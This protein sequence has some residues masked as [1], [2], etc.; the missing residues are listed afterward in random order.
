[1]EKT[2]F[3]IAILVGKYLG[4]TLTE[5]EE[6]TL[7]DWLSSSEK[8]RAWFER[9]TTKSY[10][11]KKGTD[12]RSVNIEDG[13]KALEN[14]R[15]VRQ[16]RRLW[17]SWGRYAAMFILPLVAAIF[18]YQRYYSHEDKVELVQTITSG[19]SKAMLILADGVPVVLE[20]QQEKV[21]KELDGT[22]INVMKEHISYEKM[23]NDDPG[24]LVYHE[25]VIPRGGEFSL[26]LSDGTEVYMNADS[27]LRFP[28]KFGRNER[29]VELEGEAYFQVARN[30]KSP[31]IVKVASMEIEVLGTEFNVSAY[32][33][34]AVI[35]TTLVRGSVEVS[36]EKSGE[37]VILH[38]GEQ[39][40]LNRENNSLN[41]STVDVSY[42]MAW[43]EGR[44]RFKEKPLREVMKIISRWYDVEVVYEDEEVKDYP[45]G[46]NFNR[47]ATI[48]P[49]LK[50]FEATGTIETRIDGRK[51]LIRKRK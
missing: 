40:A 27:K 8:N 10:R 41:V 26:T 30:E 23:A 17:V 38:P 33:E 31:F 16:N 24:K 25:L 6:R 50:V 20:Q 3:D 34:D 9:V 13:W 19:T 12:S 21:L 5:E 39:S 44:L 37:S 43:K 42:V 11:I 49:L 1:M 35:Q 51:I 32:P 2:N 4:G 29:V 48:E 15:A 36:S 28:T 18:L 7:E 22:M 14:K 45:F 46:C 47:H